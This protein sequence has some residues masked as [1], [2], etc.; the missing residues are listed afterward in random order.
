M[1]FLDDEEVQFKIT[2]K[3]DTLTD[4]DVLAYNNPWAEDGVHDE[5]EDN[6]ESKEVAIA[7]MTRQKSILSSKLSCIGYMFL[8]IVI[9]LVR[10]LNWFYQIV[11]FYFMPMVVVL[12]FFMKMFTTMKDSKKYFK[13]RLNATAAYALK[14]TNA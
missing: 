5:D 2:R 8:I 11:Y 13:Y 14:K 6:N 9:I 3:N 10:I 12:L 7:D 4:Y 1:K